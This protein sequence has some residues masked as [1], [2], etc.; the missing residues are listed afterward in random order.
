MNPT[1][2]LMGIIP[3]RDADRARVFYETTLGLHFVS[4]DTFALVFDSNGTMI[5]VTRVPEYT[6]FPFTLVGWQVPDIEASVA[7]LASKGVEF[8]LYGFPGQ[9]PNGIW[10]APGGAAKVAWFPDPD[11]NLLSLSQH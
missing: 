10:T 6:P 11:G 5:R 8:K 1:A 3:T 9:A 4:D 7:D 2:K